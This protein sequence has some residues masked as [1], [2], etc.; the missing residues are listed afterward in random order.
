LKND[1]K[2]LLRSISNNFEFPAIFYSEKGISL[3]HN[4]L[5][6]DIFN[7][8]KNT[9][10]VGIKFDVNGNIAN[11]EEIENIKK[12]KPSSEIIVNCVYEISP[13]KYK[14]EESVFYIL[15]FKEV[16]KK[17]EKKFDNTTNTFLAN[18]SHEIR[19][20]LNGIIGFAELLMKKSL[21][22]EKTKD[23][24]KIIYNNGGYLLKLITDMLDM[25]RIEAGKLKLFKTQFSINRLIYEIH[26]F[27]LLDM[28]NRNKEHILFK[29]SI[30][31]PDGND[32]IIADE[33]RIKQVIINLVA[34]SIKF[35]ES[36]SITIGYKLKSE[37]ELEFFVKDTGMGMNDE[38]VKNLFHRFSQAN[39]TISYEFGGSGLGLAISKEFIDM[40]GG[41]ISVMSELN[42]GTTFIFTL[43]IN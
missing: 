14:A 41:N 18:V 4:I 20:P 16:E 28:K 10:I 36:G 43:P 11:P 31:L 5:A 38:A 15:F 27:F 35:T 22:P 30:G 2:I 24:S 12:N 40:H 29:T 6:N 39:D 7:V 13:E 26:L 23:Y 34:N 17:N 3:F 37:S 32:I 8:L 19:T 33:L 25:S 9:Y 42:K 1:L 21:T